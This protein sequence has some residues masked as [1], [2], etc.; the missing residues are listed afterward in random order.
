MPRDFRIYLHDILESI[1]KIQ[2]YTE[3]MTFSDFFSDS[4]T[5]KILLGRFV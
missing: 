4:K 1:E 2:E 5:V 3:G